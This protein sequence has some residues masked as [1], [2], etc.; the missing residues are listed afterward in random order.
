MNPFG[1]CLQGAKI[2]HANRKP[3]AHSTSNRDTERKTGYLLNN[4]IGFSCDFKNN[5]TL[6]LMLSKEIYFWKNLIKP[7]EI[8][9]NLVPK[10]LHMDFFLFLKSKE[11]LKYGLESLNDSFKPTARST[12]TFCHSFAR[13]CTLFVWRQ[14]TSKTMPYALLINTIELEASKLVR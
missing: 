12:I 8:S 7:L 14:R 3:F 4:R 10:K 1:K 13:D 9:R 11:V 6:T 5:D 2:K